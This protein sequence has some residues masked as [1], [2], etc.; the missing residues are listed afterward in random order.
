MS[1]LSPYEVFCLAVYWQAKSSTHY[2]EQAAFGVA[3]PAAEHL[4]AAEIWR[5]Y[6]QVDEWLEEEKEDE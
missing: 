3:M 1:G 2:Q 4:T 5:A 6:R